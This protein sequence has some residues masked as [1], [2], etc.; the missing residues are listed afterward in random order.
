MHQEEFWRDSRSFLEDPVFRES[1]LEHDRTE[2]ACI[3]MDKDAQKD[4]TYRMTQEEYCRYRKNWWI[5]LNKS[6]KIGPVRDRSDFNDALTT[7]NRLHQESGERQLRVSFWK[8][9]QWYSSSSSSS[10]W[11]R[12]SDSWWSSWQ[13][14]RK[15]TTEL[16]CRADMIERGD[17]LCAVFSQN[18]RRVDFEDVF[19]LLQLDR[20]QLTVVCCNRQGCEHHTSHR[21]F[22]TV[23]HIHCVHH[24]WLKFGSAPTP[25]HP[26]F[27]RIVCFSD[28][29]DISIHFFLIFSL[30][31]LF[32]LLPVNFIFQDVVDKSL[33]NSAEDLGTLAENEPPTGYEP[34]E[35]HITEAYVDYTQESTGEQRSPNDFD[36][37]D[38][39][40]GKALSDACR[41]WADHSEEERLSSCLSSS[42]SHDRTVRPVVCSFDS[43]VF[44]CSSNS[45]TQPRKWAN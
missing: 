32:F 19:G 27:M 17:P 36:Y 35:Y 15:S 45:E 2:E 20:L 43:Q 11:W 41:R 31:T 40:I 12:L 18:L 10:C 29:F 13:L 37:D 34:N 23:I 33:C 24:A 25:S 14:T 39:T 26:C 5:S 44:E 22:F 3:Q 6:G 30:T 7:L 8:Y 4:F 42:V 21:P 28:C 16:M 1:Q 9:Q 38:V